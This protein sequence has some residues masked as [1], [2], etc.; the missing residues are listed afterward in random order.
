MEL[1]PATTFD[2]QIDLLRQRN[3][4]INDE[5]FC[6]QVLRQI[7]YYRFSAYFLPFRTKNGFYMEGTNFRRVYRIYEFDGKMRQVLF[8]AIEQVELYLRAQLAYSMHIN[9]ARMATWMLPIMGV[10]MTISVF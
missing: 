9:T 7:N 6:K 2:E 8:S 3:C 1:K 4:L 10:S 5:A